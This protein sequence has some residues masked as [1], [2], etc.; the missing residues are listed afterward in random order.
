MWWVETIYSCGPGHPPFLESTRL[1]FF[2]SDI[3]LY[4]PPASSP[5]LLSS[6]CACALAQGG[7]LAWFGLHDGALGRVQVADENLPLQH[8]QVLEPLLVFP[9]GLLSTQ[10]LP[11]LEPHGDAALGVG[12]K[13]V[14]LH[15]SRL[16]EQGPKQT[17]DVLAGRGG[18]HGVELVCAVCLFVGCGGCV[19]D[20]TRQMRVCECSQSVSLEGSKEGRRF[21]GFL[22]PWLL[23]YRS[24]F[25]THY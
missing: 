8:L 9:C 18:G 13:V 17:Q 24:S 6:S 5:R 11:F 3:Y 4:K 7:R 16:P 10:C 25:L 12:T 15:P 14:I 21:L 19:R 2:C 1:R 23:A 22:P 20:E